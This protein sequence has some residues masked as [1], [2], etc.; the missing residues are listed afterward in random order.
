M[1]YYDILNVHKNA[2]HQ[3]IKLNF[4]QLVEK[5]KNNKQVLNLLAK[6][7]KIL[8]DPYLRGRYD[9]KL[10]NILSSPSL[11]Q[12]MK[13]S[14]FRFPKINNLNSNYMYSS[15]YSS[16]YDSKNKQTKHYE[17]VNINNNGEKDSYSI[18]YITDK[19]G[20]KKILNQQ[21]NKILNNY[22]NIDEINTSNK[23]YKLLK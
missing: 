9:E 21:G 10:E 12:S 2:S 18:N 16:V 13:I 8:K 6:S 11:F 7:Y 3:Q 14:P 4:K 20:N 5:N 15:S 19:Y 17:K 1:N 23:H 22:S